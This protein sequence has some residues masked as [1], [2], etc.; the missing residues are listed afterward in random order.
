MLFE[1][2]DFKLINTFSVS[3]R[4]KMLKL[5]FFGNIIIYQLK[6]FVL[7][8]LYQDKFED[9]KGVNRNGKTKDR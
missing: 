4:N 3:E 9:I 6:S 5:T 1:L 2:V 7:F 8:D